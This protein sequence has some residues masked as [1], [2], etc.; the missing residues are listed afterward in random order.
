M[1]ILDTPMLENPSRARD[2]EIEAIRQYR[3][4]YPHGVA[5]QDLD[6]ATRCLWV[7]HVESQKRH[8]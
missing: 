2:V 5:W 3:A 4:A 1:S 6:V 8:V 7:R